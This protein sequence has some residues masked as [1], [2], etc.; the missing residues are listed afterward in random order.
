MRFTELEAD[1]DAKCEELS[2]VGCDADDDDDDDDDDDATNS[3]TNACH[4]SL[5]YTHLPFKP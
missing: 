5:L 3:Y 2:K 4:E 1:Y